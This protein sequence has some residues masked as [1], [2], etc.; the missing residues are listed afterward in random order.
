MAMILCVEDE[1]DIRHDIVE[2][3]QDAGFATIEAANGEVGLLE[4]RKHKPDLVLCDIA[5]P[6]MSGFEL[7]VAVKENQA[8]LSG[9]PFIFLSALANQ[10]DIVKGKRLGADDYLVKPIDFDLLLVTVESR[11]RQVKKLEALRLSKVQAETA[12]RA[13]SEFLANMSHELRTPLNAIIGFSEIIM[14]ATFGPVG[15]P[16]YREYA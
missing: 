8:E 12:D 3:L 4:I 1:P 6:V 10:E 7:L 15:S 16:K 9:I 14:A 11:L 13:K 5:M 2:E